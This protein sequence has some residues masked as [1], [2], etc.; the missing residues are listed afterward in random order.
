MTVFIRILPKIK[1]MICISIMLFCCT[2]LYA[3]G[4][5][6][7][8]ISTGVDSIEA[9]ESDPIL[10]QYLEVEIDE[11]VPLEYLEAM[12]KAQ[13]AIRNQA[14]ATALDIYT[15]LEQ[16]YGKLPDIEWGIG[17]VYF[18]LGDYNNALNFYNAV[19]SPDNDTQTGG[20]TQ[21]EILTRYRRASI[22]YQLDLFEQ[23]I[24]EL[25][26]IKDISQEFDNA[27]LEKVKISSLDEML[28]IFRFNL[29]YSYIAQREYAI[30]HIYSTNTIEDE[31][32]VSLAHALSMAVHHMSEYL[33][34]THLGYEFTDLYYMIEL[35]K[36]TEYGRSLLE[37]FQIERMLI[38]FRRYYAINNNSQ[39]EY[40]LST[41]LR[42]L[43]FF[44]TVENNY[45]YF[46]ILQ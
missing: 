30:Y 33:N 34:T 27:I 26:Y 38:A 5:E 6:A 15:N 10:Q 35:L 43:S 46:P 21:A 31:P 18:L 25:K 29:D 2:N 12:S 13:N 41:L 44:E 22:Y 17:E 20:F 11:K 39:Q 9:I 1:S 7:A 36:K 37:D 4:Q 24:K 19:L 42:L 32:L 8:P 40:Y 16:T 14:Y 3:L 28:L 45:L 23:F